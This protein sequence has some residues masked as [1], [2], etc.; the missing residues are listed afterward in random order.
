MRCAVWS[1]TSF[2][3]LA[4]DGHRV[5]RANRLHP[6][7]ESERP[8]VERCLSAQAGPVV[9]AP[10]YMAAIAEQVRPFIPGRFVALGTD[11][12]GRSDTRRK[13]RSFFEVDRF[14]ISVAALSSLADEG[15][16]DRGRVAEAINKYGVDPDKVDPMSV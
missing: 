7:Q 13:L 6:E 4:R 9:A 1:V 16:L 5:D 15:V 11:G 14:A 2:S 10:D 12:Y 8:F 3:E